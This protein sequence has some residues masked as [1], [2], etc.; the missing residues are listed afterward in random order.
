MKPST[1]NAML[2]RTLTPVILV[3]AFW[4]T[5]SGATTYYLVWVERSNQRVFEE[6]TISVRASEA[7]QIAV[8][9]LTAEFPAEPV[10]LSSFQSRWKAARGRI[11]SERDR[12]SRS[13]SENEER[14]EVLRLEGALTEFLDE[15]DRLFNSEIEDNA[16]SPAPFNLNAERLRAL[17]LARRISTS[18][19]ALFEFNQAL[20]DQH[21]LRRQDLNNIVLSVRWIMLAIGP[22][23]GVILGWRLGMHLHRSITRIAVTLHDADSRS[24]RDIGSVNIET[25]T[26][27]YDV[28][29]QAE[30]LVERM[31]CVSRELLAARR[32][33]LQSERLA[34]V[35]E[36]AAG[37]A[38]EIRNPLTS[39]KLLLQHSMRRSSP[40][41]LDEENV[42]LILEEIGRME[43]T[44]QGLLDFSRP[45]KLNRIPHD[46][47]QTLRRAINLLDARARQQNIEIRARFSDTPLMV[48]G[49]TEKLHQVLVNLLINAVDAMPEGGCLQIGAT[50][51]KQPKPEDSSHNLKHTAKVLNENMAQITILDSGDGISNDVM[52]R[53]FEPFATTKENGTG[54]GL[55]VSLR[56]AEEHSGTIYARNDPNGGAQFTLMIP[57]LIADDKRRNP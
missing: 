23:I 15:F 49:D 44:I 14:I 5:M 53:L 21:R 22:L 34:A 1:F 19:N 35:G 27:F 32:E 25:T 33:V 57:C 41:I 55:A 3:I 30:Q 43:S 56:I 20:V 28:E 39:V 46:L 31:K 12:L 36:L 2:A 51:Q 54:L 7:L 8:W 16:G 48:D 42:R 17:D 47:R 38:H 6:N 29:Q 52:S 18:A 4:I 9:S 45:P 26:E 40:P 50:I 24:D 11:T 37:V 10:L 13:A